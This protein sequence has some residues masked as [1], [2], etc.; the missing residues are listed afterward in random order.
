MSKYL[1]ILSSKLQNIFTMNAMGVPYYRALKEKKI[2][3]F[4]SG[5][6][7]GLRPFFYSVAV[8]GP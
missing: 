6:R 2:P 4:I 7:K 8:A 5:N 1:R 3:N